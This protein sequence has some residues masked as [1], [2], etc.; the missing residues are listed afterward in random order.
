MSPEEPE[1][2]AGLPC[3]SCPFR[4]RDEADLQDHLIIRRF[5]DP[6]RHA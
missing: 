5:T 4:G 3:P 1:P 6:D 2:E